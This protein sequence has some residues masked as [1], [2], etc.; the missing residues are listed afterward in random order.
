MAKDELFKEISKGIAGVSDRSSYTGRSISPSYISAVGRCP[1][2]A[3]VDR[4]STSSYDTYLKNTLDAEGTAVH[5]AV[6]NAFN[7]LIENKSKKSVIGVD[8]LVKSAIEEASKT[9]RRAI[10][11]KP[12]LHTEMDTYL[13]EFLGDYGRAYVANDDLLA[14]TEFSVSSR[15]LKGRQVA[16][17]LD[18]LFYNR[19]SRQANILDIKWARKTAEE[20]SHDYSSS[21]SGPFSIENTRKAQPMVYSYDILDRF[22]TNIESVSFGYDIYLYDETGKT[23]DAANR[24]RIKVSTPAFMNT[25]ENV[26]LLRDKLS[27]RVSS[28]ISMEQQVSNMITGRNKD[29][30]TRA[31]GSM[32]RGQCS[33]GMCNSCPMRYQCSFKTF[34]S[35]AVDA[36]KGTDGAWSI[37][38]E[39]NKFKHL[40]NKEL[41]TKVEEAHG[42]F[43]NDSYRKRY[44][45]AKNEFTGRGMPELEADKL[46]KSEAELY[47]ETLQEYAKTKRGLFH[48]SL[49]AG[50]HSQQSPLMFSIL[51][52]DFHAS[53]MTSRIRRNIE[54]YAYTKIEEMSHSFDLPEDLAKEVVMDSVFKSRK[55]AYTLNRMMVDNTNKVLESMHAT[56]K[57][58]D[59]DKIT[60]DVEGDVKFALKKYSSTIDN[61]VATTINEALNKEFLR[62][63]LSIDESAIEQKIGPVKGKSLDELVES[64]IKTNTMNNNINRFM[65]EVA[66]NESFGTIVEKAGTAVNRFP[67][68]SLMIAGMLSYMAGIDSVNSIISGKLDKMAFYMSHNE[69]EIDAA[70]HSSIYTSARRM[71]Y[72]DFGSPMRWVYRRSQMVLNH[73]KNQTG[74]LKDI[75]SVATGLE[76]QN[77]T[78]RELAA[79]SI[80]S[81]K[82]NIVESSRTNMKYLVKNPG[83]LL[84]G[85]AAGFVM[86]GILPHIKTSRNVKEAA[87]ER[88]RRLKRIKQ[89]K[90]NRTTSAESP[91]GELRAWYRRWLP[92]GSSVFSEIAAEFIATSVKK[93]DLIKFTES[94]KKIYS[95]MMPK[96]KD[97]I[98]S[99]WEGTKARPENV[100]SKSMI[101]RTVEELGKEISAVESERSVVQ[102]MRKVRKAA[103][104]AA[105]ISSEK[106]HD[107][108][109]KTR[110]LAR[111]TSLRMRRIVSED[112]IEDISLKKTMADAGKKA[113]DSVDEIM[114]VK[115]TSGHARKLLAGSFIPEG[116][117]SPK[118]KI[119]GTDSSR[120][121]DRSVRTSESYYKG[122]REF[123]DI[124]SPISE[125]IRPQALSEVNTYTGRNRIYGNSVI[126]RAINIDQPAADFPILKNIEPAR[127]VASSHSEHTYQHE[128]HFTQRSSGIKMNNGINLVTMNPRKNHWYSNGGNTNLERIRRAASRT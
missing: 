84:A 73:L 20:T 88:K 76:G 4:F 89:T 15:G 57:K 43:L 60:K 120:G 42:E 47:R 124:D 46:A 100:Y 85:T 126:S 8:S 71:M 29:A 113:L 68:G 39:L 95:E 119:I 72:S 70:Q 74:T 58:L 41:M 82:T 110:V 99:I 33:P 36:S 11:T 25:P 19:K 91:E 1:M 92:I 112:A 75:I 27:N 86:F 59:P 26:N 9:V 16:G 55:T 3:F 53:W 93:V 48:D 114:S 121:K 2:K 63:A 123:G 34:V 94:G 22:G 128:S 21:P 45:E 12:E 38:N 49:I 111:A 6:E 10:P 122:M 64:A 51:D 35:D 102:P 56:L 44:D 24:R 52:R 14:A 30:V 98:L 106:M 17:N 7:Y 90:W 62:F 31:L 79:E 23:A 105:V 66:K 97:R 18:L 32:S 115:S 83:L 104:K 65:S 96:I 54:R 108:A 127:P 78:W 61:A 5:K 77:A 117:T 101:T 109:V 69:K 103:E 116:G 50:A 80:S 40:E 118:T 107:S 28:V 67:L 81:A 13:K 87:D 125:G 37:D